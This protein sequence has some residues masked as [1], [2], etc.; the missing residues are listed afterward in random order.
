MLNQFANAAL[1][2]VGL[3]Y[4]FISFVWL[5]KINS[6]NETNQIDQ[7]NQTNQMNHRC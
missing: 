2:R 3:V 6:M 4:W 7:I 1:L 5:K